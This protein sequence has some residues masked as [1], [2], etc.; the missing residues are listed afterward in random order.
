MADF[1]RDRALNVS[2][3]YLRPGAPFGGSCLSKDVAALGRQAAAHDFRAPLLDAILPSNHEHLA[4]VIAD[5]EATA[6]R[7]VG[8]VGLAFKA[9]TADLRASPYLALARALAARGRAVHVWDERVPRDDPGCDPAWFARSP[10]ALADAAGT[11]VVCHGS[12]DALASIASRVTSRHV[13]VDLT[14]LERARFAHAAYRS[15]GWRA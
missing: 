2:A 9:G 13:V 7:S 11:I 8:I 3:A 5:V 12:A 4:R 6:S 1:V 14:G 10:A 15:A